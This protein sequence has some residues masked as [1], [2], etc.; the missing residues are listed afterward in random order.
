[1]IGKGFA[2][3]DIKKDKFVDIVQKE[4]NRRGHTFVFGTTRVGKTRLAENCIVQDIKSGK[5]VI[6]IDPKVDNDLFSSIYSAAASV[7]REHDVMLLTTL[8]PEY[9]LKINPLANYYII[10]EVINHVMAGVPADD[11]FFYKYAFQI[12]TIIV[13]GLEIIKASDGVDLVMTFNEIA[14]YTSFDG[15]MMIKEQLI[16]I[17]ENMG[18][19]DGRS[20]KKECLD[21]LKIIGLASDVTSSGAEYIGKVSATLVA[22]LTQLTVGNIATVMGRAKENTF[23]SRIEKGEGAILYVQTGSM[24]QKD[25]SIILGKVV[26]SMTQSIIGRF[27]AE[28]SKFAVPLCLYIDE[29][30]NCTYRGIEDMF[31]KAGGCNCFITG[32]TQSPADIIAEIGE[33]RARKLFDNTNTKIFMRINDVESAKMLKSYGGTVVRHTAQL[34]LD[35]G[36]RST[37]V[38][39]EVLKES[40]FFTLKMRE[41]FYFGFEGAFKGKTAPT[42]EGHIQIELPKVINNG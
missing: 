1:M 36:I 34:S 42:K 38:E 11:E 7:G 3:D 31:N 28:G 29:M 26:V 2:L 15:L 39:E 33:D 5:N 20:S 10:D 19:V 16:A 4:E 24:L 25:P 21:I 32:L 27:F 40:D 18:C 12:V 22:T 14:E 23:I 30:S 37:E 41:F 13:R 35:G 17:S 8:F 9:S 6:V